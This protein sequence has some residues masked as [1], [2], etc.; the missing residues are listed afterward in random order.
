[1]RRERRAAR[2][3]GG[4]RVS[5]R[6]ATASFGAVAAHL[7]RAGAR[8]RPG[9]RRAGRSC[10]ASTSCSASTSSPSPSSTTTGAS[11]RRPAC[12][13]SSNGARRATWWRELRFD[14]RERS[15]PGSR[16]PSS[17]TRPPS[18]DF[19]RL[20][21]RRGSPRGSARAWSSASARRAAP[22][23]RSD[24]RGARG[25]RARR[26]RDDRGQ[27]ERSPPRRA[28]P[29]ARRSP[30]EAA[31]ALDRTARRSTALV[32]RARVANRLFAEIGRRIRAEF[33]VAEDVMAVAA[34][35][36]ELGSRRLFLDRAADRARARR[37]RCSSGDPRAHRAAATASRD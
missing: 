12:S 13:P 3:R 33:D 31:L 1:M 23:S 19:T 11:R 5:C 36:S 8:P 29:A 16:A 32:G 10:A 28:R 7:E 14:L 20:R 9:E 25:R 34:T 22:G 37:P 4:R 26:R 27:D 30:A 18:A 6:S 2:P 17:L 15:L 21:R 35:S 24:R